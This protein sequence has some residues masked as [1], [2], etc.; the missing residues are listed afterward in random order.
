MIIAIA[1][2]KGG[3]G[4]TTTAINLAASIA[5]SERK[6]LLLDMDSQS[7]ATTGMGISYGELDS[8]I[9]HVLIGKKRLEEVIRKTEIPFLD[10]IPSHPDLIGAEVELL[11]LN[12]KESVLKNHLIRIKSH[13]SYI[14]IDCPPSL[15]LLTINALVGSDRVLIPLQCEYFALEGLA[16]LLRTIAIIKRRLNPDLEILGVLLTMFD[17]RNSLSFR[18]HEE[19]KR[20]FSKEIFSTVIPRNVRLIEASS[21]GKPVLL[22]DINSK[23]AESYLDLAVEVI[24]RT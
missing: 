14:I 11:D 18:V 15:G 12:E 23:G 7:N 24:E 19:V 17:K 8:H 4:K 22:Y 3:V 10:I 9:Y 6:T 16:L 20:Y 2:Q 13:Y 21:Y 1:N 5:V